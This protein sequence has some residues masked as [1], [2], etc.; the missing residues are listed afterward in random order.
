M[1]D[2]ERI[3]SEIIT[4]AADRATEETMKRLEEY[5]NTK[6]PT[7]D[8][9]KK[10]LESYKPNTATLSADEKRAEEVKFWRDI[11]Q[12]KAAG[13]ITDTSAAATLVPTVV[14]NQILD[15][16]QRASYIRNICTVY[17]D[18]KG[19]LFVKKAGATAYRTAENNAP[20]SGTPSTLQYN[21]VDYNTYEICADTIVSN[22]LLNEAAPNLLQFIYT[23]L[24]QAFARSEEIEFID[25][26]A[27]NHQFVGL[28]ATTVT[29]KTAA[30]GH[31]TISAL[32]YDD[33]LTAFLALPQQYR[34]LA[35][36]IISSA[37]EAQAMKLKNEF[38]IPYFN[39]EA[40]TILGKKYYIND[41][42]DTSG[43]THPIAYIGN[44]QDYYVLIKAVLQ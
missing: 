39:P 28:D 1:E 27:A 5:L 23:Q 21:V 19:Y 35:S 22:K 18:D 2:V 10:L 37:V 40:G 9:I 29:T 24:G 25:G 17:P 14:A 26:T 44:W 41:N 7:I 31:T 13:D 4:V 8:E 11:A 3:K 32:S 15:Q 38:G 12:G 42:L 34:P 33:F 20:N 36:W 43:T 6:L 16:V 30:S